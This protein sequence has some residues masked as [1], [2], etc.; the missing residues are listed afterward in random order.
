MYIRIYWKVTVWLIIMLASFLAPSGRLTAGPEHS[1]FDKAIHALL[2]A[3]FTLLLLNARYKHSGQRVMSFLP[4]AFLCFL[5]I[6][7]GAIIE[8]A[9]TTM[10][11][12]REGSL[13]DLVADTV[14]FFLGLFVWIFYNLLWGTGT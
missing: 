9:Q 13:Y 11:L 4:L 6:F 5:T 14:G 2:F 3:V 12:G 7:L 8:L 1:M 10:A